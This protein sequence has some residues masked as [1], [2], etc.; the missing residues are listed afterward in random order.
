MPACAEELGI[1]DFGLHCAAQAYR[2]WQG[3]NQWSGWVAFLSFFQDVAELP[4]DYSAYRHWRVLA[5]R[6][7]PRIV[8][9]DFCMISDR[10]SKLTIDDRNRPHCEDGP[11]CEWRDGSQ[12]YAWQGVRLPARWVLERKTID[13]AEIIR[14]RNVEQRNAGLQCI[15]WVRAI[16]SG[17]IPYTLVD[18]DPDPAH[19]ELIEVAFEELPRPGRFLMAECPRNGPIVEGVPHVSDIDGLPIDSVLA[20]QAWRDGKRPQE[21]VYPTVRT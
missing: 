20:A 9:P 2:M 19:G 12:L 7:G 17:S 18:A 8:H 11:Y 10:P 5:E 14:E 15:G 16:K 4:L 21:F 13:P 6:S 3:G 1:G